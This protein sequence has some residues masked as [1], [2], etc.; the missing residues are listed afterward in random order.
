MINHRRYRKR[1]SIMCGNMKVNTIYNLNFFI[2]KIN[3]Y[4]VVTL[5]IKIPQ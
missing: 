2:L 3:Y 5:M 1:K 4:V